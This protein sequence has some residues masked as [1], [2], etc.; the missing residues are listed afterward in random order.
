M[1][2]YTSTAQTICDGMTFDLILMKFF[3][4]SLH[5]QVEL[6]YVVGV[7]KPVHNY[8]RCRSS[9]CLVV[10]RTLICFSSFALLLHARGDICS[11]FHCVHVG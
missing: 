2:M 10:H 3:E 4:P 6:S 8:L 9:T 11:I 1:L 5:T 7:G